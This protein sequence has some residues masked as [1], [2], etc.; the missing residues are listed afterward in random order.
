[1]TLILKNSEESETLLYLLTKI[2]VC[3]SFKDAGL[4]HEIP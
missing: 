3:Y 1:M 2:L 4:R